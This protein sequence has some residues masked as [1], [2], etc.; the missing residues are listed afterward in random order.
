MNKLT[1]AVAALATVFTTNAFATHL[2]FSENAYNKVNSTYDIDDWKMQ[3]GETQSMLLVAT[4]W[5]DFEYDLKVA[6]VMGGNTNISLLDLYH[7]ATG[8]YKNKKTN[9]YFQTAKT[10]DVIHYTDADGD[11][12][13]FFVTDAGWNNWIDGADHETIINVSP[14]QY[15]SMSQGDKVEAL[16]TIGAT[17]RGFGIYNAAKGTNAELIAPA[18]NFSYKNKYS[19]KLQRNGMIDGMVEFAINGDRANATENAAMAALIW[20]KNT[21]WESSDFEANRASF[22]TNGNIDLNSIID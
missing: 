21:D 1:L 6:E 5:N 14:A 2:E 7:K 10:N 13:K 19:V 4:S 17:G 18:A 9:T 3:Y 11:T 20:H 8:G 12:V 16:H 15:D 22:T